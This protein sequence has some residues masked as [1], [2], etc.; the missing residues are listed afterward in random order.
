MRP[1]PVRDGP[2][3]LN[4][5]AY[6]GIDSYVSRKQLTYAARSVLS[7]SVSIG[8]P[9]A[10]VEKKLPN[11]T[12]EQRDCSPEVLSTGKD[13]VDIIIDEPAT[14]VIELTPPLKSIAESV[15]FALSCWRVNDELLV[16]DTRESGAALPTD[17]LLFNIVRS[18]GYPL[19]QLPHPDLLRWPLFNDDY[20]ANDQGQA[21]AMVQAY[22]QAQVSKR[23]AKSILL[24]GSAAAR[25][26]LDNF[27][28]PN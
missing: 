24:M 27:D 17:T 28:R 15:C 20:S 19:T 23:S 16:L 6:L 1:R 21:R 9:E 3:R 14:S 7:D 12:E 18:I 22:I 4:Y 26:T 11:E 2:Q 8:Y 13:T 25:F 10:I 5:L